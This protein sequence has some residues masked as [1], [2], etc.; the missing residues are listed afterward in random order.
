VTHGLSA[1]YKDKE[2]E[3]FARLEKRYKKAN[4]IR[5]PRGITS[6]PDNDRIIKNP[7]HSTVNGVMSFVRLMVA[8]PRLK[9]I[10]IF[11]SFQFGY[12]RSMVLI[13]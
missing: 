13:Q 11:L 6:F 1:G 3:F 4:P 8:T 12:N 9:I 10:S 7:V 2:K 5:S